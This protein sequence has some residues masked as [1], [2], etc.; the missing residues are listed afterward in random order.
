MHHL[1]A[2]LALIHVDE[3]HYDNAAQIAQPNLP[4]DFLDGIGIGFND[5]IFQARRLADIFARIDVDRH[6]RFRLVDH[7]VAAGFQPDFGAQ[8]LLQL[9]RHIELV[10]NRRGARV[11][12]DARDHGRLEALDET[13]HAL[14]DFL[15]IHPHT[16]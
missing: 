5:G 16:L 12:F 7:D 6:Q 1:L 8:R 15:V 10:E 3:I 4:H 2:I 14:V 11:K 13:Q 9:L